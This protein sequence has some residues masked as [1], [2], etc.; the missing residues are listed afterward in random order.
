MMGSERVTNLVIEETRQQVIRD[1]SKREDGSWVS[2]VYLVEDIKTAPTPEQEI[3]MAYG[4]GEGTQRRFYH[5]SMHDDA[6]GF[7]RQ[8]EA[9]VDLVTIVSGYAP[10]KAEAPKP[11]K[12]RKKATTQETGS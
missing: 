12:S 11:K 8:H 10:K 5:D 7:R 6:K 1:W 2:T 4:L 9:I 3:G